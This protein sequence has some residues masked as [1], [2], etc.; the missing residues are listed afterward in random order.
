M[1]IGATDSVGDVYKDLGLT[2]T[3]SK[4][5]KQQGDMG[6]EDFLSLMTAQL[7]NQDPSAPMES[8]D[9]LGQMAQFGTVS[10]IQDL[11]T[12]FEGLAGSLYSNQ[13]LQASSLVGKTALIESPTGY[14]SGDK[15]LNGVVDLSQ[16]VAELKLTVVDSVGQTVKQMD[17][18]SHPEGPVDFSWDGTNADGQKLPN[19]EYKI[20]AE[21]MVNGEA[22]AMSTLMEGQIDSV[23][24]GGGGAG[25]T[26]NLTGL[27]QATFADIKQVKQ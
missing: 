11:Q 4:D 15:G 19:G 21:A 1:S 23:S 13:A 27:G 10:G 16:S 2:R 5:D 18:G 12:S 9:F 6:Q 3:P 20:V 8:G 25:L 7:K 24:L 26:F 14:L 17:L 22:L